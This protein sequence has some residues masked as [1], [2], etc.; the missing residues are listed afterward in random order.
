M[1][2]KDIPNLNYELKKGTFT[3]GVPLVGT[4]IK[5]YPAGANVPEFEANTVLPNP[6]PRTAMLACPPPDMPTGNRPEAV[7]FPPIPNAIAG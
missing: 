7:E 5:K 1:K 4:C 6:E 3:T 2:R